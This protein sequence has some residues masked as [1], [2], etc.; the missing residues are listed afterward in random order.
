[1]EN[2]LPVQIDHLLGIFRKHQSALYLEDIKKKVDQSS[3]II[4]PSVTLMLLEKLNRDNYLFLDK[5]TATPVYCITYEG[6]LF[7]GY[8]KQVEDDKLVATRKNIRDFVLTYGTAL[9]GIAGLALLVW[10]IYS[11]YFLHIK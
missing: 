9:A 2:T 1:M 10:Q 5:T 11:N 6:N 4:E 7:Q 8:V 3:I